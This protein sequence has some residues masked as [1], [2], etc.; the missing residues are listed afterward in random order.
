[1]SEEIPFGRIAV[2][3]GLIT[4]EQ[5]EDALLEQAKERERGVS[6]RL[7]A[8]L[9]EKGSLNREDVRAL[10]SSQGKS[11]HRCPTCNVSYTLR[12]DD[13]GGLACPECGTPLAPAPAGDIGETSPE[14]LES[15][16]T[17][18]VIEDD[19]T[20]IP[21]LPKRG[22]ARESSLGEAKTMVPSGATSTGTL[23]GA[24]PRGALPPPRIRKPA[25]QDL[26]I[27]DVVGGCE[28][29]RLLGRGGMG[30]VYE[31]MH[32]ALNKRVALKI[33]SPQLTDHPVL[34]QRFLQ[35]ART[36]AKLDHPHVV[37]VQDVGQDGPHRYIVMQYV[38]GN[39]LS[40]LLDRAGKLSLQRS[41]EIG[42]QV[43]EALAAAHAMGIVHRD[44]KP[45][46]VMIQPDGNAKIADFG[47]AKE[48]DADKSLSKAGQ[49]LGSPHYL[50]PE[51]A[52]GRTVDLRTDIYSLGVTLYHCISGKRPFTARSPVGVIV[53]H[54]KDA[55]PDIR[56]VAPDI[57]PVVATLILRMMAKRPRDR[58]KD[59]REVCKALHAILHPG[60]PAPPVVEER[61]QPLWKPV[62]IAAAIL[63]LLGAGLAAAGLG[64]GWIEL[65]VGPAVENG[66]ERD[67]A[68]EEYKTARL[69][70]QTEPPD[71]DGA[72]RGFRRLVRTYGH[73]SKWSILARQE[74]D[75]ILKARDDEASRKLEQVREATDRALDAKEFDAA[76]RALED[77]WPDLTQTPAEEGAILLERSVRRRVRL[78]RI[79]EEAEQLG[80]KNRFDEILERYR[81]LEGSLPE[82]DRPFVEEAV[83]RWRKRKAA[84]EKS[85]EEALIRLL[86]EFGDPPDDPRDAVAAL[87]EFER[88]WAGAPA[89]KNAQEA[90]RALEEKILSSGNAKKNYEAAEAFHEANPR[91][92]DTAI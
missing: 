32:V 43:A 81:E 63:C 86:E 75:K 24:L 80:E 19:P 73:E 22:G 8:I 45:G 20:S 17:L 44:V 74:I 1:M 21:P 51:Q 31:A 41:L 78:G 64:L 9:V 3:K 87:H 59:C 18:Y 69:L 85:G 35:E 34:I 29:I 83:E 12:G 68:A 11:L 62:A 38:E 39:S 72:L 48:I 14:V 40:Q 5:L 90:R 57:P 46:N 58:Y 10:L 27:G 65:P 30:T 50:S 89:A 54:L 67:P 4:Q 77:L 55:P 56:K 47:L 2:T 84:W 91:D 25:Q 60:A 76:L 53:K 26:E 33:L 79:E 15:G 82:E 92:Y 61:S 36:A 70:L 7:G 49:V 16:G 23:G 13:S 28:I 42:L 6:R 52:D 37:Q 88:L 66:R 71:T